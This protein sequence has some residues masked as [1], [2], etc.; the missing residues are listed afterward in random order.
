MTNQSDF[1]PRQE[2]QPFQKG[3]S[4][5]G[6]SAK[7]EKERVTQVTRKMY[8]RIIFESLEAH[9][10]SKA[11]GVRECMKSACSDEDW[12]NLTLATVECKLWEL[13]PDFEKLCPIEEFVTQLE[14]E[15]LLHCV[16]ESLSARHAS[17][18]SSKTLRKEVEMCS[19]LF[20]AARKVTLFDEGNDEVYRKIAELFL[21]YSMII[22][23]RTLK[24]F[25]NTCSES[26]YFDFSV[27]YLRIACEFV[28]SLSSGK[29][30]LPATV[31][32]MH[33]MIDV[34]RELARPYFSRLE[35]HFDKLPGKI[36]ARLE[37]NLLQ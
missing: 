13:C 8:W 37:G 4:N 33:L 22:Q 16:D 12:A 2:H 19:E 31:L 34:G 25:R 29:K 26:V 36:K 10:T 23:R 11:E 17:D 21:A 5:T 28:C 30:F 3:S 20:K 9:G 14:F 18:G 27:G 7:D 32:H 15:R 35:V 6:I 24:S 1:A